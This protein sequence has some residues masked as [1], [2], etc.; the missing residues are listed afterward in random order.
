MHSTHYSNMNYLS[1]AAWT[2]SCI[3]LLVCFSPAETE[4]TT[5][6]AA[7]PTSAS[8]I[9]KQINRVN[10]DGSY[11]IGYEA[12]DGTFKIETRDSHG[13]VKGM[14]GFLDAN[15]HIKR[16]AYATSNS[17]DSPE[18]LNTVSGLTSR[19]RVP[20]YIRTRA[21]SATPNLLRYRRPIPDT[22]SPDD[23]SPVLAMLLRRSR[24]GL[25]TRSDA[26]E[27]L[28]LQ[29]QTD[30]AD[31]YGA[32]TPNYQVPEVPFRQHFLQGGR[33]R[34]NN[35]VLQHHLRQL[36][37]DQLYEL[38][39]YASTAANQMVPE[40]TY[41]PR[42]PTTY[43]PVAARGV[44]SPLLQYIAGNS[45]EIY[46]QTYPSRYTYTPAPVQQY[47]SQYY[48]PPTQQ[49]YYPSQTYSGYNGL[50]SA[51][52]YPYQ[53]PNLPDE[54]RQA[55]IFRMLLAAR[56]LGLDTFISRYTPADDP[57]YL[58]QYNDDPRLAFTP[59]QYQDSRQYYTRNAVLPAYQQQA[60]YQALARTNHARQLAAYQQ[61]QQR[62]L[63]T[64]PT[65]TQ[66]YT[67]DQAVLE[68]RR[69]IGDPSVAPRYQFVFRNPQDSSTSD[70]DYVQT[71]TPS[72]APQYSSTT[73]STSQRV[74]SERPTP[75]YIQRVRSVQVLNPATASPRGSASTASPHVT[76]TTRRPVA[77]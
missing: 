61:E 40:P 11:T 65:Y 2:V 47:Q 25:P 17:T 35:A 15:G 26:D 52:S 67:D 71:V 48:Y 36:T 19:K 27:L 1:L 77:A 43:A 51:R 24:Q 20:S 28:R 21:R 73:A 64:R 23:D 60:Y 74:T 46:D 56:L 7:P 34:I 37:P 45:R 18:D 29:Q 42:I 72:S 44:M 30:S 38:Q 41:T 59:R 10:D 31:V 9:V 75:S 62:Q 49:A 8:N 39:Q 22:E 4:A 3:S 32:A 63:T 6:T 13:N 70:D 68:L 66:E 57:R 5:T 14:F 50:T 33:G 16:V 55:L 53:N 76:S 69:Q 12:E 58:D 54:L